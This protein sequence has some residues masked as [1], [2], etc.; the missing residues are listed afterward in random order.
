MPKRPRSNTDS[1]AIDPALD[2]K[3][4]LHDS[5]EDPP[6][7]PCS[8][9]KPR[10]KKSPKKDASKSPKE[11]GGQKTPWNAEEDAILVAIL[12]D[13]IKSAIWPLIKA[14][15]RLVHRGSSGV[16]YHAKMLL[17]KGTGGKAK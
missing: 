6:S 2:L 1:S 12:N 17:S 3:P 8:E 5:D 14:D 11:K 4:F 7:S 9:E 15:G 10:V 16:Q 13:L